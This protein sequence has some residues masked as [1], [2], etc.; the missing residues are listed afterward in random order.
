MD[1]QTDAS[2]PQEETDSNSPWMDDI[3]DGNQLDVDMRE[4]AG[5][6]G[7]DRD[8][9]KRRLQSMVMGQ[10]K[11]LGDQ[12]G[13]NVEQS[14]HRRGRWAHRYNPTTHGAGGIRSR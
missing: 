4:V 9:R 12:I 11:Q 8:Q 13:Q 10:V 7:P 2:T 14:T 6:D 1:H 5:L 3:E